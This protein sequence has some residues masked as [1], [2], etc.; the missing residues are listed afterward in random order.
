MGENDLRDHLSE[1]FSDGLP[2]SELEAEAKETE[3]LLLE[4]AVLFGLLGDESVP[5]PVAAE[6]I[7]AEIPLPVIPEPE[8]SGEEREIP[9]A[10]R[11]ITVLRALLY[12][13]IVLGGA[14]FIF[15][16]INLVWQGPVSWTPLCLVFYTLAVA[17]TLVQWMFNS[18]LTRAIQEAEEKRDEALRSRTPSRAR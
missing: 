1:L 2:E 4:D 18:S 12:G 17:V 6:Q 14:P 5:A 7:V 9:L 11:R 13:L 10:K 16:L 15:L 8:D 3:Q